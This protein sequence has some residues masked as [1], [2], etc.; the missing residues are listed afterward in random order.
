VASDGISREEVQVQTSTPPI[1]SGCRPALSSAASA[2]CRA[3]SSSGSEL[4]SRCSIPVLAAISSALIGDQ[5]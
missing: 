2:A 4:Y 1:S 5:L 3:S